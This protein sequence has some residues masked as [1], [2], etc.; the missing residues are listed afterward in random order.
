MGI[1][2]L[3]TKRRTRIGLDTGT[4]GVR[5]VQLRKD[6]DGYTIVSATRSERHRS[7]G[8]DAVAISLARR[9]RSCVVDTEFTGRTVATA[10]GVPE[11]E[12]HLL[13]LP[14]AVLAQRP[15]EAE[16]AVQFEVGRLMT[17]S[18]DLLETRHWPLP[19]GGKSA[20]NAMAVSVKRDLVSH[21]VEACA[22]AGLTCSCMDT[23][24][25]ALSRL[26]AVLK[27]WSPR[28]IWGILDLGYRQCR[29][30]LCIDDAP[31]LVR[32]A[33]TGGA[34]WTQRIAESLQLSA[35]AAEIHKKEHGIG[36]VSRGVRQSEGP[37][38]THDLSAILLG[39]LRG[40]LTALAAEIKRSYEYVLSC[41]TNREVGDLVLVGGGA[42]LRNLPE[43][44]GQALG[45][46]V[47]LASSY[48]ANADCRLKFAPGFG[49]EIEPLAV[50]IGLSMEP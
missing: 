42:A 5:A 32:G 8:S 11:V 36:L 35:K 1:L 19:G 39:A 4:D 3:S 28:M 47:R 13:D 17:E 15:S 2:D 48:M 31:V 33:G 29:L 37:L 9:V 25:G 21:V 22:A 23:T 40:D 41:Y 20:P 10:L 49:H 16:R 14:T 43:F 27:R 26:G 44:L 7:G 46:P 50:A 34:D 18:I 12:F 6:Q 24:A 45:I 30:V 38:P